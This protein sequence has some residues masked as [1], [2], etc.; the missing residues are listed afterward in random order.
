MLQTQKLDIVLLDYLE[1]LWLHVLNLRLRLS[2]A[3]IGR[4]SVKSRDS[5]L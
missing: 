1:Y 4:G 2:Y 5:G 3:K